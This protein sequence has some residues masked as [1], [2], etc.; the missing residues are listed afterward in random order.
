M[1][2]DIT[3]LARSSTRR[4]FC[5][6]ILLYCTSQTMTAQAETA[7]ERPSSVLTLESKYDFQATVSRL[8]EVLASR[9]VTLFADI[10]QSAAATDAGMA[11][12]P[13]RLFLFGNPKSG[14]PVMAANAHAALELP[15]KAVVWE[16][17]GHRVHVDYQDVTTT[18]GMDYGI[19]SQ[20]LAPLQ[21]IPALLRMIAGH[22]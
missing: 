3:R 2:D 7:A 21:Q 16:D 15:L 1:M 8:K 4:T 10:D 17:V 6:A 19:D 20:T 18:L 9:G 22:D 5:A 12:R 13:T 14:T 11:L